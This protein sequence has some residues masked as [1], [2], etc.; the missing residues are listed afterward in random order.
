MI[1][2]TYYS[3]NSKDLILTLLLSLILTPTLVSATPEVEKGADIRFNGT[4]R[5]KWKLSYEYDAADMGEEVDDM[6]TCLKYDREA[7]RR[8]LEILLEEAIREVCNQGVVRELELDVE[9]E[10]TRYVKISLSFDVSNIAVTVGEQTGFDFTWKALYVRGYIRVQQRSSA[11][12]VVSEAKFYP[13]KTLGLDWSVFGDKLEEWENF[14]EGQNRVYRKQI[15][16]F[17]LAHGVSAYNVMM[18]ITIPREYEVKGNFILKPTGTVS[19]SP[20]PESFF[21][22]DATTL[23]LGIVSLASASGAFY[24]AHRMLSGRGI[25]LPFRRRKYSKRLIESTMENRIIRDVLIAL[26]G[27]KSQSYFP[28]VRRLGWKGGTVN[29]RIPKISFSKEIR[30]YYLRHYLKPEEV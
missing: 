19:P 12:T 21:G 7:V 17:P 8:K 25:N 24:T 2:Q 9:S 27:W 20:Q 14:I 18:R 5:V 26:E 1:G 29:I 15:K 11:G 6:M 3:R 16:D 10:I 30:D 28:R 4:I 22:L 23:I 13:Y